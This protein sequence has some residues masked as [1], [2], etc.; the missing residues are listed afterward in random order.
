M[1]LLAALLPSSLVHRQRNPN[2][3][4]PQ[5]TQLFKALLVTFEAK[6]GPWE[7]SKLKYHILFIRA[8]NKILHCN[9]RQATEELVNGHSTEIHVLVQQSEPFVTSLVNGFE[10]TGYREAFCLAVENSHDSIAKRR[11]DVSTMHGS[12]GAP[13]FSDIHFWHEILRYT[14][15]E[16]RHSIDILCIR[17]TMTV[18]IMCW[19]SE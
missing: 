7:S 17:C 15:V 13:T 3:T 1:N 12:C 16:K 2:L 6:F 9:A 11:V 19:T 5:C 14:A 4:C 10:D 18:L 8:S